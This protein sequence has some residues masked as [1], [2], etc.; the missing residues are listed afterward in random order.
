MDRRVLE[1]FR[2]YQLIMQ[3]G[4]QGQKGKRFYSEL[5]CLQEQRV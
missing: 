5:W 1:I 2:S 4:D 3:V